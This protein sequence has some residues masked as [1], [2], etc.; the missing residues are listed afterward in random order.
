MNRVNKPS[1]H[2]N[3]RTPCVRGS[4]GLSTREDA[5]EFLRVTKFGSLVD[6]ATQ[7]A[8]LAYPGNRTPENRR[9]AELAFERSTRGRRESRQECSVRL[10]ALFDWARETLEAS[11]YDIHIR[12]PLLEQNTESALLEYARKATPDNL[13]AAELAL[14][15]WIAG[16]AE[17]QPSPIRSLR[18]FDS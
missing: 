3:L 14:E 10:C 17:A 6:G 13:N 1:W 5:E 4:N 12:G 15:R 11:G 18:P 9:V 8:L 7:P 2:R 16:N